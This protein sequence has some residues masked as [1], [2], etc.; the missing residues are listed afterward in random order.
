MSLQASTI[1]RPAK[2]DSSHI[3]LLLPVRSRSLEPSSEHNI[4]A[5][6]DQLWELSSFSE[7]AMADWQATSLLPDRTS[8][9]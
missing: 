6:E 9:Q 2:L 4:Q 1:F 3:G 8:S 5:C 7:A